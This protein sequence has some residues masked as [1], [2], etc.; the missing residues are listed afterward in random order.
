MSPSLHREK[1]EYVTAVVYETSS[2]AVRKD[3]SN[4]GE[5]EE[6]PAVY[7]RAGRRGTP[8][9]RSH[10]QEGMHVP[11]SGACRTLPCRDRDCPTLLTVSRRVHGAVLNSSELSKEVLVQY[12][13]ISLILRMNGFS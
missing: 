10:S 11:P 13:Q 7:I 8:S 4:E 12:S 3:G 2:N 6:V 9:S 1:C 5:H